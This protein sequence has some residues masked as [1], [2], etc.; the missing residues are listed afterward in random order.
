ML[1]VPAS[2]DEIARELTVE[3]ARDAG[4]PRVL[5]L[6]EPQAAFYAWIDAAGD[7]WDRQVEPGQRIL[8]CDVGGGTT[9]LSLIEVRRS[10]T[11]A[12]G[13]GPIRFHRIAVGDHLLLGGD[14][15]DL[16]LAHHV[17]ARLGSA[18]TAP[19]STGPTA[20]SEE[21][22][23]PEAW[24]ALVGQCQHA[25]ELLLGDDPPAA[26]TLSIPGRGARLVGG[27]RQIEV[28]RDEVVELL[29][30]G[31]L[32]RAALADAPRE[33]AG[34]QEFGL[35]YAPDPGVTRYAAR[36]LREVGARLEAQSEGRTTGAC[37]PD[38][39]LVN[40]GVMESTAMR[41]APAW[42]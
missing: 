27:A 16:A 19:G 9:D 24:N 7:D 6:E 33:R 25:K 17:E 39:L 26:A 1:T 32:P 3:A 13:E 23:D 35:P 20:P 22:L 38:Y 14:N 5:L 41:A 15:M 10:E 12:D 2:F 37:R 11:A 18:A 29:L 34:F 42:R 31:F 4:L 28:S 8:V 36:F 30:D 21:P 40:G